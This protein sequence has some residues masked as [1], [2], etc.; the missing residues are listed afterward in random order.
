MGKGILSVFD[1]VIE[2]DIVNEDTSK[3][4]NNDE[5]TGLWQ[6]LLEE[7]HVVEDDLEHHGGDDE[8]G[9]HDGAGEL[10]PLPGCEVDAAM[11][12]PVALP[13]P[14]PMALI[15]AAVVVLVL[16][17]GHAPVAVG[18]GV[19]MLSLDIVMLQS[20]VQS[21][22]VHTQCSEYSYIQGVPKKC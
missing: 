8:P 4:S 1:N 12:L 7:G 17:G 14:L 22:S 13:V 20:S 5:D 19:T 16:A 9:E 11:L 18:E 3:D 10:A 6:Q 15:V 21:A 2:N